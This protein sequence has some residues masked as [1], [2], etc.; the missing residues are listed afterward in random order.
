MLNLREDAT[1]LAQ[2]GFMHMSR[3]RE[4]ELSIEPHA[5][6][7]HLDTL[8]DNLEGFVITHCSLSHKSAP[9]SL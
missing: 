4:A 9:T 8:A 6:F 7:Q 5:A 3:L 2:D 1:E